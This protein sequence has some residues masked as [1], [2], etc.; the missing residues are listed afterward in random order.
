MRVT[1]KQQREAMKRLWQ[2]P[3]LLPKESY[4]QFRRGVKWGFGG[5]YLMVNRFGMWIG[6]ERDGYTHT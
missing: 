2:R 3:T 1:T 5:E 4:L 6:I